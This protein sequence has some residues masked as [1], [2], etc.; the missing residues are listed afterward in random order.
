M[1]HTALHSLLNENTGSDSELKVQLLEW[2]FASTYKLGGV[3]L[4]IPMYRMPFTAQFCCMVEEIDYEDLCEVMH[5]LVDEMRERQLAE[6]RTTTIPL[7]DLNHGFK[8]Q[9]RTTQLSLC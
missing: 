9:Q 4:H 3:G 8:N 6:P 7:E 1:I 5:V 2:L